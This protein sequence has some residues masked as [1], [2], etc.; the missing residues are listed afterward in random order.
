[1]GELLVSTG[2]SGVSTEK[3]NVITVIDE[4]RSATDWY[5][6]DFS[7]QRD[8]ARVCCWVPTI[9][10]SVD[11]SWPPRAYSGKPDA[12][13]ADWW[14]GRLTGL[15]ALLRTAYYTSKSIMVAAWEWR[16]TEKSECCRRWT[17]WEYVNRK[18]DIAWCRQDFLSERSLNVNVYW[19]LFIGLWI[20]SACTYKQKEKYINTAFC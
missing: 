12:A 4:Q 14:Y 9:Q 16:S 8:V 17:G 6:V 1:V 11:I 5:E 3:E 20:K 2:E 10:Q 19:T 18:Y 15:Y 7:W 13:A